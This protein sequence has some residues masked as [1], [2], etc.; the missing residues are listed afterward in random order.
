MKPFAGRKE[1]YIMI[2]EDYDIFSF[3]RSVNELDVSDMI[4]LANQEATECER[5]FHKSKNKGNTTLE[6][7]L[8]CY[9]S[10]LKS[11]LWSIRYESTPSLEK[12]YDFGEMQKTVSTAPAINRHNN[13]SDS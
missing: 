2:S 11:L 1:V 12:I 4:Q 9:T 3:I 6:A 8:T 7:K 10:A 13:T 5:L